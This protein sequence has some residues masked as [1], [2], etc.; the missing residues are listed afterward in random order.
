TGPSTAYDTFRVDLSP[1][2]AATIAQQQVIRIG[3]ESNVRETYGGG[4]GTANFVDNIFIRGYR[5]GVIIGVE[6]N[7]AK[8]VSV[9]PNP[10]SD[11]FNVQVENTKNFTVE[12]MD[13]SGRLV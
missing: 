3:F 4:S 2:L 6:N 12:V 8:G 1:Y 9:F 13:L 5:A 7:F 11:M 10:S